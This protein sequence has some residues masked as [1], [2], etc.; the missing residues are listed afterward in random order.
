MGGKGRHDKGKNGENKLS[1]DKIHRM[2]AKSESAHKKVN[3]LNNTMWEINLKA[4]KIR[5][6]LAKMK[7]TDQQPLNGDENDED[8]SEEANKNTSEPNV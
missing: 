5:K 8:L 1:E 2:R 4:F 6:S 7:S 3:E